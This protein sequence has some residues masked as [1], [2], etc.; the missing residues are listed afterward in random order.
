MSEY[1]KIQISRDKYIEESRGVALIKLNE[2]EFLKG[3]P[4]MINYYKD[5]D[6]K[7][8][9]GTL[10]AIGIGDGVGVDCYRLL[11]AGGTVTV[12]EV[13]TKIP[14]V[15]ALIHDEIYIYHDL[16]GNAWYYVYKNKEEENRS[17]ELIPSG[18][19]I[20]V[21]LESGYR[22]FYSN[23]TCRRE[24]D[25]FSK[26]EIANL[27]S[28]LGNTKETYL[29]VVS[30]TGTIFKAGDIKDIALQIRNFSGTTDVSDK[31]TYY[32]DDELIERD[33]S[34][35]YLIRNVSNTRTI[36]VRS[37]Y[38][39]SPGLKITYR[40]Q[41][42]IR[43]GYTFYFGIVPE[44]WR[45]SVDNILQLPTQELHY[46]ENVKYSELN[47]SLQ[48]IVF[49][50]P[51]VYGKLEHIFDIHGL[52]YIYDYNLYSSGIVI[53]NTQYYVYVKIDQVSIKDFQQSFQFYEDTASSSNSGASNIISDELGEAWRNKNAPGGFL[54]LD[55]SGK[56][57]ESLNIGTGSGSGGQ[58]SVSDSAV[59]FIE[60]IQPEAPYRAEAGQSFFVESENMIYTA[61]TE[62]EFIITTPSASTLYINRQNHSQYYWTGITLS[63][64]G[65]IR[66][67]PIANITDII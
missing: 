18:P 49:A 25:F 66:S 56:L 24:D 8:N 43:F 51:K 32:I 9:I 17:V 41:I 12:R 14:D 42:T 3:E 20:F 36:S 30:L 58:E 7:S 5:P 2:H 31:C 37:D 45:L 61:K 40:K 35:Q 29:E 26:S 4:V 48:K 67:E 52:D 28:T 60:R 44:D 15:S 65:S 21:D 57:P 38:E 46:R 50:Y 63:A 39:I 10:V 16:P 59:L 11:S 47:L 13:T 22:W 54:V 34:G 53:E 6:L 62:T 55:E 64:L 33:P 1:S 27:L 23:Q 19:F